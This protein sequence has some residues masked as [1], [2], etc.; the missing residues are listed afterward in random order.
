MAETIVRLAETLRY[1]RAQITKYRD[2]RRLNEQNTKASLILPVL[3]ALGW[4]PNDPDEVTWE[5]KPRPKHNPVDFALQLK[6]TPCLILEAKV[7]R[8]NLDEDRLAT[9]LFSEVHTSES[10]N[11]GE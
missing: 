10:N 8:E 3:D 9:Q 2:G 1:V 7:L 4:N 11:A 6:R 5:Y